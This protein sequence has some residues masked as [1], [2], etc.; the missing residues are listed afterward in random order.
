LSRLREEFIKTG[1]VRFV[2]KHF[3]VLGPESVRAAVASECA[4][5]QDRFWD[6]HDYV[7]A[8]QVANRTVLTND[9]L[10]AMAVDLSMDEQTF[11]ECLASDRYTTQ[12]Q[13]ESFSVQSL[14]VR[15]TPGFVINGVYVAGAQPYDIFR[16]LVNEQLVNQ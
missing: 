16:Q 10:T 15:G 13:Q 5:E 14:G 4:A 1:Q 2:Y 11:A 8:D 7:Y 6:F 3:A 12:I 9:Q